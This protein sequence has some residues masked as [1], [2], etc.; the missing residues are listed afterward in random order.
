MKIT[1]VIFPCAAAFILAGLLASCASAPA[2]VP[3]KD[4]PGVVVFEFEVKSAEKA[5]VT[6]GGDIAQSITEALLRGTHL[7]PVERSELEK[8]M[9]EQEFSASG[10]VKEADALEVGRLSGARYILLGSVSPVAGQVRINARMLDVET[11][12]IVL[13][14]SVY[15]KRSAIYSLESELAK[16][17]E[18]GIE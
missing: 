3:L 2:K 15:G 14:D 4:R 16:K 1:Q 11:A 12:E 13:A 17:I 18:E 5:D 10:M 9:V 6:L 8:I 7:R